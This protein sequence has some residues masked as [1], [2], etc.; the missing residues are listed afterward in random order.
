VLSPGPSGDSQADI[1]RPLRL[2]VLLVGDHR[3]GGIATTISAYESLTIRGYDVAGHLIFR[4]KM[5]ANAE[6]LRYYFLDRGVTTAELE[7]PPERVENTHNDAEAMRAY[8]D[9]IISLHD[10]QVPHQ[11]LPRFLRRILKR[12]ERRR[13]KLW[14]MDQEAKE[15]IWYPFTQHK[16]LE[17]ENIMVVDSAHGDNFDTLVKTPKNDEEPI[18]QPSFDASAS[19]WTQG[20]GH[21]NPR[22]ALAAAYAAGRYGHVMFANAINKPALLL[23]QTLLIYHRNPNLSKVFYSDNGSTG[24]EVAIKMALRASSERHG[25]DHK[26]DDIKILGLKGSYH[27]DTMGVMDSSEPSTYNDKVEWYRPKGGIYV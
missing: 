22:L 20:V 15:T 1:Y 27:G 18:L 10:S 21:S 16:F 26:K 24:M 17:A 14:I 3:L 5:Y 23:A 4:E 8:Y 12:E 25:W 2:P 9:K 19:W 11:T 6:Y 13:R 7:V